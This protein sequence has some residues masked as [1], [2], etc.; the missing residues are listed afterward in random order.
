MGAEL[1]SSI[2][3]RRDRTLRAELLGLRD[4]QHALR[5][6]DDVYSGWGFGARRWLLSSA[7]RLTRSMAPA[8]ADSVAACRDLLGIEHPVEVFV[9]A[10][11]MLNASMMRQP[12]G[13][14]MILLSSRLVEVFT[15][16]ELRFVIGHELGHLAWEH[17]GIPMPATATVEDM[18][19]RMVTR[20]SALK[21]YLWCRAAEVSADR[22]GLVCAGDPEAAASGF[23]KLA[24]GLSSAYVRADLDTYA[25]QIDSLAMTPA[26]REKPRDDDDTLDCFSTH[27][28]SPLRVRAVVAF[29]RSAAYRAALGQ[30]RQ[31]FEDD[32]LEALVE[33]DL[34]LMSPGYLEEKGET[35]AALRRLLYC[36]GLSVAASNGVVEDKELAALKALLGADTM[37]GQHDPEKVRDELERRLTEAASLPMASRAQLVQHLTIVA[38]AD[39]Q[40]DDAELAEMSRIADRLGV[41]PGVV[42]QTLAAAAHPMD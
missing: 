11:A 16:A 33:R 22:A 36:A 3:A 28:Y 6:T 27:P 31:G 39:G 35:Q 23:F 20:A 42:H 41:G 37:W 29:S 34:D 40:V 18:A 1:L 10:D 12:S 2:Q 26:A 8:V 13:P 7:L 32:E 19:G 4:V 15:P 24:S 21:L 14:A 17:F 25:A 30:A 9:R 5:K 38:A